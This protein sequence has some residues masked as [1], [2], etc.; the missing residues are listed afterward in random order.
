MLTKGMTAIV[1][2]KCKNKPICCDTFSESR[3]LGR[4]MLRL[5]SN[6]V[7]AGVVLEI[8]SFEQGGEAN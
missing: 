4:F 7:A 1:E 2:I 6:T 8:L 5:K 3:E